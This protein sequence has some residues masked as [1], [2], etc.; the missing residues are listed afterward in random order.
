MP[1][2]MSKGLTLIVGQG[3]AGSVLGWKIQKKG[4]AIHI[5]E[6]N[7]TAPASPVAAGLITPIMGK[8]LSLP[9]E[10]AHVLPVAK[11][12]YKALEETFNCSLFEER[13]TQ[14]LF[15]SL[16]EKGLAQK[17]IAD[18][19]YQPYLGPLFPPNTWGNDPLGGI[20]ILGGGILNIPGLLEVLGAHFK[21]TQCTEEGVFDFNQLELRDNTLRYQG[22]PYER[23]IFAE[24]HHVTH[25][26]FFKHLP[27]HPTQGEILTLQ[28]PMPTNWQT[29][30]FSSGEWLIPQGAITC[31]IGATYAWTDNPAPTPKARADLLSA[32]KRLVPNC[33]MPVLLEQSIGIRLAL[34]DTLPCIGE[35]PKHPGLFI[36][37]GF[38][39]KGGLLVPPMADAFIHS[40]EGTQPLP[41]AVD[42]KRYA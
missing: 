19:A 24:G 20:S 35:H 10:V 23:I 6:G 29:Q 39:S 30:I 8:R 27:M 36:F 26:P 21:K 41:L 5:L 22:Q 11:A 2:K 18:P 42:V 14:R 32:F 34:P 25:N 17:K 12:F 3:I 28:A 16:E 37:N 33:F 4:W 7:K 13:P 40:L 38:A 1:T 31:R 15:S 9:W